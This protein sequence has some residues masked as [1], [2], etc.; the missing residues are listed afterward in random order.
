[1]PVRKVLLHGS[2][3]YQLRNMVLLLIKESLKMLF[4]FVMLGLCHFFLLIAF[5]EII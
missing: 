3:L 2:Q 5:V 1:L 4:A